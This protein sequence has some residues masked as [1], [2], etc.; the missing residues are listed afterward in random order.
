MEDRLVRLF[1]AAARGNTDAVEELLDYLKRLLTVSD[2]HVPIPKGLLQPTGGN[3]PV[4][5]PN[6]LV[7]VF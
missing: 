7:K 4:V 2:L 1:R 3:N 6:G 5:A